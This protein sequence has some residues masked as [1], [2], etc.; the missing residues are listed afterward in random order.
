SISN[1]QQ[2]RRPF[3]S[4]NDTVGFFNIQNRQS[5]G[6]HYLFKCQP[7]GLFEGDIIAVAIFIDFFNQLGHYFRIGIRLKASSLALELL[8]EGVIVF[9]DTIM[10]KRNLTRLT[11]MRM[12]VNIIGR[13]VSSPARMADPYLSG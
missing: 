13:S 12:R 10:Y 8:L 1:T 3:A 2:Q 7:D 9:D 6:A 4:H 5:V 11:Y